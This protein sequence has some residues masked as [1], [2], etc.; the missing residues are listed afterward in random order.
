MLTGYGNIAP[1]TA[2]G[3]IFCILFAII[4]VPF[5]LSVIADV[6]QLNAT[7]ISNMYRKYNSAVRPYL[8][9]Y[10]LVSQ[11]IE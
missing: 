5:T 1:V 7:C 6:G 9:K 4:G 3:R 8:A 10:N 2:E 11:N